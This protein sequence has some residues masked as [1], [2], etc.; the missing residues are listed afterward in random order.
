MYLHLGDDRVVR[1]AEVVA[2]LDARL[3][4]A[5]EANQRFFERAAAAGQVL[6]HNLAGARSLVLTVRGLYPSPIS[7]TTLARRARAGLK[8]IPR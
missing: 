8:A 4:R 3:L 1:T 7:A 5:S 6:G 2:I